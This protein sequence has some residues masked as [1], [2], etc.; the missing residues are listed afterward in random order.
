MKKIFNVF[1]RGL[2]SWFDPGVEG[3]PYDNNYR[4]SNQLD[5][6]FHWSPRRRFGFKI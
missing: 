2:R 4:P 6:T 5:K 1:F 3:T